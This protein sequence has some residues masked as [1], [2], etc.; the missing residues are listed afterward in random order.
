MF[1]YLLNYAGCVTLIG[2]SVF[3]SRATDQSSHQALHRVLTD[4]GYRSPDQSLLTWSS[5]GHLVVSREPGSRGGQS[6]MFVEF[7]S[8]VGCVCVCAHARA[9]VCV[10]VCLVGCVCVC[11]CFFVCVCVC[12][13]VFLCVQVC[14]C[15]C[16]CVLIFKL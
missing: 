10:C 8:L 11:V 7:V 12:V 5:V 4:M 6:K 13:C 14:V 3:R 15:V 1:T 16:V 9:R 2:S